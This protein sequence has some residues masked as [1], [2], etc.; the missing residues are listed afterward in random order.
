[1]DLGN[2]SNGAAA[3][4]AATILVSFPGGKSD[5]RNSSVYGVLL[6]AQ[7]QPLFAYGVL[8]IAQLQPPFACVGLLCSYCLFRRESEG[9]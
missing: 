7:L 3:R 9:K 6:I 4:A 8:L 2:V 1:M 5:P